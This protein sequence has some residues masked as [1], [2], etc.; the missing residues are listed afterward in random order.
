MWPVA[1]ELRLDKGTEPWHAGHVCRPQ[2]ATGAQ[3]SATAVL[4]SEV[5][6]LRA[7]MTKVH[8]LG[9]GEMANYQLR[10]ASTAA[11]TFAERRAAL[12]A[13]IAAVVV[14]FVFAALAAC[15][16]LGGR[17][18][19]AVVGAAC[20][21]AAASAAAL[22]V[23]GL[24][25]LLLRWPGLLVEPVSGRGAG[26]RP[27]P[28]DSEGGSSSAAPA[29]SYS[30]PTRAISPDAT[31]V[32]TLSTSQRPYDKRPYGKRPLTLTARQ[33]AGPRDGSWGRTGGGG[34]DEGL[35]CSS[36]CQEGRPNGGQA[37]SAT[38]HVEARRAEH[39]RFASSAS[40]TADDAGS[41]MT[42]SGSGSSSSSG[43]GSSTPDVSGASLS[44]SSTGASISPSGIGSFAAGSGELG[45]SGRGPCPSSKDSVAAGAR[46]CD[47]RAAAGEDAAAAAA[48]APAAA[49]VWVPAGRGDAAGRG[50][51]AADETA[52]ATTAAAAADGEGT[53][54][55]A[56]QRPSPA[57]ASAVVPRPSD[58]AGWP[59]APVLLVLASG[60]LVPPQAD[61]GDDRQCGVGGAGAGAVGAVPTPPTSLPTSPYVAA[62]ASA[63]PTSPPPPWP[64]APLISRPGG[65]V[66][67]A[68]NGAQRI[69]VES[70]LF[71]GELHLFIRGLPNAPEHMFAGKKRASWVAMQGRF[72]APLSLESVVTGQ[73]FPRPLRHLPAAW[74]VENVM[75]NLAQQLNPSLRVGPLSSPH[76]LMPLIASAQ[77]VNVSEPGCQPH[78]MACPED[79]RLFCPQL[80]ARRVAAGGGSAGTAH[81]Q[82][83]SSEARR[84]Y[85]TSP[86]NRAGL[87]YDTRRVWTFLYWQQ[88]M[89]LSSYKLDLGG[90]TYDLIRHL[91]GQPL[92]IMAKDES[93][94]RYLFNV[95][96][97]HER[98]LTS[99]VT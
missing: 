3:R 40:L 19:P 90:L 29:A 49:A 37:G 94:S 69:R 91:D 38:D 74:F 71:S 81:S 30:A 35:G 48:P 95:A 17:P 7:E 33:G 99:A 79:V 98:L 1:D 24:M 39:L 59:D 88:Y 65:L 25:Q 87:V 32:A 77:L 9:V 8:G 73:E 41:G 78:V 92:Q 57:T 22:A 6:A 27:A 67:L 12:S 10:H 68:A 2:L 70:E 47:P 96:V 20:A 55:P 60:A 31:A 15:L 16:G 44:R 4:A 28:L 63:S 84:R 45:V 53:T 66:R 80:T 85:F 82:P 43:A 58:F 50:V 13:V 42:R 5:A 62:S 26:W 64:S 23:M 11:M 34:R 83:A 21:V 89:D 18:H 51:R 56:V 14:T 97:W 93:S 36:P 86:R 76:L 72:K 54:S 61:E 46:E 52:T 75:I